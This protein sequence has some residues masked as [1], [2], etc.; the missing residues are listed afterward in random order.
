[1]HGHSFILSFKG[2]VVL[3]STHMTYCI[4]EYGREVKSQR[5]SYWVSPLLKCK[6]KYFGISR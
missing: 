5:I 3:L 1:M 2:T 4:V 6:Y